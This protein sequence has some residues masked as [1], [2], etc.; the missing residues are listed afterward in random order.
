MRTHVEQSRSIPIVFDKSFDTFADVIY[1]RRYVTVG[2]V[3]VKNSRFRTVR[4]W[5]LDFFSHKMN[6]STLDKSGI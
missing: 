6:F 2:A 3:C 4:V 5:K 1:Q